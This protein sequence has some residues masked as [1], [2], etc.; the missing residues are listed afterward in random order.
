MFR[1]LI[2]V[3]VPLTG[4]RLR[5][6]RC[7]ARFR[8]VDMPLY[9]TAVRRVQVHIRGRCG[10]RGEVSPCE[11]LHQT[12]VID[13]CFPAGNADHRETKRRSRVYMRTKRDIEAERAWRVYPCRYDNHWREKS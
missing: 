5:T 8:T 6:H 3:V 13:E 10:V 2:P 12:L 7:R 9:R 11:A 4:R 1:R